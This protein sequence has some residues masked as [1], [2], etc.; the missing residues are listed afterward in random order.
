MEGGQWT[1]S[2]LGRHDKDISICWLSVSC[3]LC[4]PP[5]FPICV[6]ILERLAALFYLQFLY[7]AL[8]QW[9]GW[10]VLVEVTITFYITMYYS[11]PRKLRKY[12]NRILFT[13]KEEV[14]NSFKRCFIKIIWVLYRKEII[15]C[16]DWN[17]NFSLFVS[18]LFIVSM[19]PPLFYFFA[20]LNRVWLSTNVKLSEIKA[21]GLPNEGGGEGRSPQL[22]ITATQACFEICV[23]LK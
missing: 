12:I 9:K 18:T 7:T 22:V 1:H 20:N 14:G 17:T 10:R 11:H 5:T 16:A 15:C 2:P 13:D 3:L 6:C 4:K 23:F 8:T 21:R 19:L